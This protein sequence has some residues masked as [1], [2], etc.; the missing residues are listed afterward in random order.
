LAPKYITDVMATVGLDADVEGLKDLKA[1]PYHEKLLKE[2]KNFKKKEEDDVIASHIY[3]T[4]HCVPG[5]RVSVGVSTGCDIIQHEECEGEPV[6][7]DGETAEAS[8]QTDPD[9]TDY[10][11]EECTCQLCQALAAHLSEIALTMG[12][13]D[14]PIH[15]YVHVCQT[16]PNLEQE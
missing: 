4:C 3:T 7:Y 9:T 13:G 10:N 2:L 1:V 12:V 5:G 15:L 16:C 14:E 6:G 8:C 11:A